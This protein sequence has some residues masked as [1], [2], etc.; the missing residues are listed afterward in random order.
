MVTQT[1]ISPSRETRG[2]CVENAGK[3]YIELCKHKCHT[4]PF[5]FGYQMKLILLFSLQ[6]YSKHKKVMCTTTSDFK[7]HQIKMSVCS[8]YTL[9]FLLGTPTLITILGR[10]I[11]FQK[12][13]FIYKK[14]VFTVRKKQRKQ[15]ND[16]K[17]KKMAGFRGYVYNKLI[18]HCNVLSFI[19]ICCF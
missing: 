10:I 4:F 8:L 16:E 7:W 13:S 3:Y 14:T 15:F 2:K 9:I 11:T 1:P 12:L 19:I 5:P 6:Q 18:F 17:R